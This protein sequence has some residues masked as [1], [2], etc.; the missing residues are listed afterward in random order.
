MTPWYWMTRRR[1]WTQMSGSQCC[2]RNEWIRLF[3][4]NISCW[5]FDILTA[6]LCFTR[7]YKYQE[8]WSS[9]F[10][11]DADIDL[12]VEE[13][14]LPVH[15][16]FLCQ[17]EILRFAINEN[18]TTGRI[19]LQAPFAGITA[20]SMDLLLQQIYLTGSRYNPSDLEECC[21]I[22]EL[23]SRLGFNTLAE[24][25]IKLLTEKSRLFLLHQSLEN[26]DPKIVSRW[27]SVIERCGEANLR[28]MM[29]KFLAKWYK[30]ILGPES[31]DKWSGV[32]AQITRQM[33]QDVATALH[34]EVYALTRC[35]RTTFGG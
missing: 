2:G 30:E 16:M 21:T 33:I 31:L 26:R 22:L 18:K 12:I 11:D 8:N 23:A 13:Q 28:K 32:G 20:A 10:R 14:S 3:E 7:G 1:T 25:T 17:S 5:I 6:N 15:S 24:S 27:L 34:E 4:S 9:G 19:Q 35:Q 29:A